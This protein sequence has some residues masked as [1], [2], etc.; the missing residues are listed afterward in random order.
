MAP[1]GSQGGVALLPSRSGA[2]SQSRL[3]R[4]TRPNDAA[5]HDGCGD[6]CRMY[7]NGSHA[8]HHLIE[9][10][11]LSSPP[12]TCEGRYALELLSGDSPLGLTRPPLD[13]KSSGDLKPCCGSLLHNAPCVFVLC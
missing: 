13:T 7:E 6:P 11:Q 1:L 10:S 2:P 8:P 12:R 3:L 4:Q 9:V 5:V